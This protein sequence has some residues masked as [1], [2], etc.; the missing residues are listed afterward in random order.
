MP[1]VPSSVDVVVELQL[2]GD[3]D[4]SVMPAATPALSVRVLPVHHVA[5]R[6]AWG[7]AILRAG[8]VRG[9]G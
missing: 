2:V 1:A 8:A 9:R 3:G 7:H 6:K 4:H 5:V